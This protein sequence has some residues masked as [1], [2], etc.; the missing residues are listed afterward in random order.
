MPDY[1]LGTARGHIV[2]DGSGA[3]DGVNKANSAVQG[4]KGGLDSAAS[5]MVRTG[6][7]LGGVGV[8][9]VAGFGLAVNAAA[10]FE[11]R[12]SAIGAVSNASSAELDATRKKAL[13]LGADTKYSAGEAATAIENLVKGGL[14]LKDVLGG[15]A[16]ATV[17]LA[18]ATDT[19]L[20]TAAEVA[21]TAMASFGLKASEVGHVADV[22]TGAVNGF[23]RTTQEFALALSQSGAV[24]KTV[25]LSFD[26][27]SVAIDAMAKNGV[28]GS[29]AG[30][31][32]KQ[33]LLNLQPTTKEQI[34][35]FKDLG[36]ITEATGPKLTRL[37]GEAIT[38]GQLFDRLAASGDRNVKSLA[39]SGIVLDRT[40]K[41][42]TDGKGKIL[43]FNQVMDIMTS[44]L[45]LSIETLTGLG[46]SVSKGGNQFFDATGKLKSMA[47]IAG[48]LQ[49]ALKGM[50][51]QQKL[52]TLETL[53]GTD[54]IRAAAIIAGE[55]ADGIRKLSTEMGKTTAAETA[56]KRMD[57]LKGS[58]EQLRGSVETAMITIGK[59]AQG[60][61]RS[62]VDWL[63]KA[64]NWFDALS[65]GVQQFILIG[66]GLIA[67]LIGVAGAFVL[68]G[69]LILK[70]A[71]TIKE[72]HAGFQALRDLQ[73]FSKMGEAISNA[74]A[75]IR[76]FN[77]V[78]KIATALQWLWNAAVDAFPLF[79]MIVALAAVVAGVIY[80]YK[81][82]DGFRE[83]VDAVG[84]GIVRAF[85]WLMDIGGQVIAF[86]QN[87]WP[88][89]LAVMF[90]FI[91]LPVLIFQNWDK[92]KGFF[93]DLWDS[94]V[95]SF[96][97]FLRSIVAVLTVGPL[98]ILLLIQNWSKIPG[99]FS[100]LWETVW[101][102]FIDIFRRITGFVGD[103]VGQVVDLGTRFPGEVVR[104]FSALPGRVSGFLS[105]V[106]DAV[107][108]WAA[109]MVDRAGRAAENF[110]NSVWN[111]LGRLYEVVSNRI[112]E[113]MN[114]IG[115]LPID[116]WN[117]LRN[118]GN[119]LWDIGR[120]I[121]QGLIDGIG[122]L[123]RSV[124]DALVSLLPG[125]LKRF[126]QE[127][128]IGSPSK[129]FAQYGRDTVAGY[130]MGLESSQ[131]ALDKAVAKMADIAPR[132]GQRATLPSTVASVAR[133]NMTGVMAPSIVS[134]V[135]LG[136]PTINFNGPLIDF[137]GTFGPGTNADDIENMLRDIARG[138]MADVITYAVQRG[139]A[140]TGTRSL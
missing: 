54:A 47:E 97:F 22:V 69:G 41:Q 74:T 78:Q 31:S 64:V 77:V 140:K 35:L 96:V 21:A 3:E 59:M 60:P 34:S 115:N 131:G 17:S 103:M 55:G 109:D 65:P 105:D 89:I 94:V 75:A 101:G 4:F 42:F 1:N 57:N 106:I 138:E 8:A 118:I 15:A 61:L 45:P 98:L 127:L 23:V 112:S 132:A 30:T 7:V 139:H 44:R 84:R 111:G 67:M 2:I 123:A 25:G 95:K 26:D 19:D 91:G 124:I 32:L 113:V 50:T 81:H 53:F 66:V 93:S 37:G 134:G 133:R 116:I 16:D 72:L 46:I 130:I 12:I 135:G 33:M 114:I 86:F 5:S 70:T 58:L 107:V 13:Q 120:R 6:A 125:P 108:R 121:V 104:F 9:A 51:Q 52:A 129:L 10:N 136:A 29:D 99:F 126:V 27:L 38:A 71:Q 49:N 110:V 20:A 28:H 79:L 68:V 117:A 14:S 83:V 48:V 56:H 62:L 63:T 102:F 82:F 90:P 87:N 39:Q 76:E 80:A 137:D 11:E 73:V 119:T 18:A 43:G 36:L 100:D 92:V 128:G 85:G 40:T 88:T 122:S 24:A